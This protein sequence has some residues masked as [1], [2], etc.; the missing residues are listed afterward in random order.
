MWV[1]ITPGPQRDAWPARHRG[2][3]PKGVHADRSGDYVKSVTSLW[4]S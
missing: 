4:V 1:N 3:T 2:R